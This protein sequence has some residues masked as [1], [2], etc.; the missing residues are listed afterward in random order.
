MSFVWQKEFETGIKSIDDQHKILVS[1]I[2]ELETA[3]VEKKSD[4]FLEVILS[5]MIKYVAKHFSHEEKTFIFTKY[6]DADN[7][8][9]EHEK[10]KQQVLD[11]HTKV[12]AK[13][14]N[15]DQTILDFLKTWLTEHIMKTD[16]KYI[17][18]FNSKNVQ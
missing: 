13:T 10:L 11:F 4:E 3:V 17:A 16:K 6:S 15:V 18:H 14:A 8:M 9:R 7:H 2:D 1:M 5:K 12:Q